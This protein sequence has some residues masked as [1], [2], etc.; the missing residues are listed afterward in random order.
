MLTTLAVAQED[1]A[2]MA[3]S[4]AVPA[5]TGIVERPEGPTY[6]DLYCAG[7]ITPERISDDVF[8]AGGWASPHQTRFVEREYLYLKGSSFEVGSRYT[9]LRRL[10][11]PNRH[12]PFPGQRMLVRKAGQPYAELG[13][14]RVIGMKGNIG[15]T[16]VE[17]SCSDLVPGDLAVPFA[18]KPQINFRRATAFDRFAHPNGKLT[19]RIVMA[20]GFDSMVGAGRTV[21]LNVGSNDGVRT[22]DYFRAFRTY[23]LVRKHEADSLSFHATTT[24]DTQKEPRRFPTSKL[25]DFPRISLGEMV[26]MHV[27][28]TSSTALMTLSIEDIQVGDGVELE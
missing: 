21:Y 27:T 6:S 20:Q 16:E 25:E 19:G 15:I 11:D 10:R 17:F 2:E 14:V 26:V 7:F 18:E 24:E 5:T 28:P 12:E 13:R 3:Q 9:I 4:Q 22:G 23:D 8:V 1:A